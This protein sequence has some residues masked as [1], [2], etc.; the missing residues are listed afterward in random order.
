MRGR[1]SDTWSCRAGEWRID[2]RRYR[3]DHV[4]TLTV[5][6]APLPAVDAPT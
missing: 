2:E 4:Q 3:H 5:A 6:D 1:Y